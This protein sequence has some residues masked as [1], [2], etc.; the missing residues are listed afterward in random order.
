MKGSHNIGLFL[1]GGY[2]S[3]SIAASIREYHRPI[4]AFTFGHSNSRDVRYAA[5]LADR[6]GLGHVKLTETEPYLAKNCRAIVWRTEGMLPFTHTTSIRYHS[7]I[8][9]TA[10]ILLLGFLNPGLQMF[11]GGRWPFCELA[12]RRFLAWRRYGFV[13]SA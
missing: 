12:G 3:R 7:R 2:D 11:L 10:D 13:V 8:K 1:S 6:L 9:E 5:A 4:S